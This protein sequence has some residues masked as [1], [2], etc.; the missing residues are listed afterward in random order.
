[1]LNIL[2]IC[3][4]RVLS[5]SAVGDSTV[6]MY[7]IIHDIDQVEIHWAIMKFQLD[8]FHFDTF[9]GQRLDVKA[10]PGSE[11]T[12]TFSLDADGVVSQLRLFGQEFGRVRKRGR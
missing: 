4:H 7:K 8:H 12:A 9:Q 1:M 5:N 11:T 6:S 3:R 10:R 2:L